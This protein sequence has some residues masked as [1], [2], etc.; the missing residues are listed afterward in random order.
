MTKPCQVFVTSNPVGSFDV[1]G[2]AGAVER[3]QQTQQ[4]ID[5]LETQMRARDWGVS[6]V[7]RRLGTHPGT[8]SR[9]TQGGMRPNPEWVRALAVIFD[10]DEDELLALAGHRSRAGTDDAPELA[11]LV[12]KMRR[13]QVTAE[14]IGYLSAT[15]EQMAVVNRGRPLRGG[16]DGRD[17]TVNRDGE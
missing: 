1:V 3:R 8:V 13:A 11:H 6:E 14:Q 15:V 5:W 12:A 10:A 2:R 4:I 9:W 17:E 16:G 7:A